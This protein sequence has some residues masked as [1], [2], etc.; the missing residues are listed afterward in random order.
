MST[1]SYLQA[2]NES[3]YQT[4]EE[5]NDAF[6]MGEDVEHGLTGTT[7]GLVEEFGPDRVRDTPISEAGFTG[8]GIGAAMVGKRPIIEY[9]INTA[10]YVAMDQVVNQAAKLSHMSNGQ[11][12]APVTITIPMA[13]APGALAGQHSDNPYPAFMNY[14]VKTVVPTTPYDAKGLFRAAVEEDDPVMVYFP[15]VLQSAEGEVP[16][17]SYTVPLGEAEVRREGSDI[18]VVAIGETVEMALDVADDVAADV[19]VEVIDP[20]TLVPLDEEAI[21][22]SVERTGR[23]IVADNANRMCGAAA[24]IASR[25]ANVG[26]WSLEAPVKRVTR[27]HTVPPSFAPPQEER[28]LADADTIETAVR[29]LA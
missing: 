21:L 7:S 1:K 6:V 25:I 19:D 4:L 13:G 17:E 26:F 10:T 2:V 27:L 28:I 12:Q 29:D 3:H 22:E 24:E 8:L 23:V 15:I 20:R 14:G 18:T 11:I 16:D 5:I 9:Q